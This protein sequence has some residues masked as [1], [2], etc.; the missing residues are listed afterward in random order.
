MKK[1][2]YIVI[3]NFI[4]LNAQTIENI[5]SEID[6]IKKQLNITEINAEND[7]QAKENPRLEN[8]DGEDIKQNKDMDKKLSKDDNNEF[9]N[10]D[11]IYEIIDSL[12]V[13]TLEYFGYKIFKGDPNVFQASTF[14]AVDP[15]Y[16]IGPG[17][18]IIVM[19][20]GESQFRQEFIIDREGYVFLPEVGQVFVN[21][22][23]LKALEKKIF[24]ILSKVYSTL[25]PAIGKPTTFMDISL[26]NL[27]PLRI[28]VLGDVSQPGSYSVSPSTSLSSSLY[29]FNGPT[30]KG[31]LRDIQL[32][33]KGKYIGSI[34]FY[35][36]LLSG[37]SPNDLRMQLDDIVFIPPRGK[38]VTILGEINREGIYELKDKEGLLD[39]INISGN[40]TASAYIKRAQISR[41]IP[42]EER[43]VA[44]MDRIL[45]DID[46]GQTIKSN[47][48]VD[49]YDGDTLKIFEIG[50]NIK[51]YV[52]ISG[53]TVQRPGKYQ[54]IENMKVSDLIEAADGLSKDVF[55][56]L[57]H[58]YRLNADLSQEVIAIDINNVMNGKENDDIKLKFMDQLI[59]YD[60]NRIQNKF[61]TVTITG[62]VKTPGIY[63]LNDNKKLNDII[64]EAGGFTSKVENVKIIVS[65]KEPDT[66]VPNIFYF[67]NNKNFLSSKELENNIEMNNFLLQAN[68]IVS[69]YADPR[70]TI[71]STINISG[72][73]MFPGNYPIR[74]KNDK[75]TD[76]IEISGGLNDDAYLRASTLIRN[77]NKINISFDKI[78]KNQ[79]NDQNFNV[80]PGDSIFISQK[81]NLV[82]VLGEVNNPG[83][84]KYYPSYNLNDYIRI[85]G[86]LTV[87]AE[88]KEIWVNY[89]DG[90]SKQ[91]N[92]F[93]P[94][95]KVYDGSAINVGIKNDTEPVNKTEL[96][97]EM[98]SIFADFLNIYISMTLLIRTAEG[99]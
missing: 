79:R 7:D 31:S 12:V 95:P 71:V 51:N 39:L 94:S 54:L 90:V 58:I 35:D 2:V 38:T 63:N 84:F 88:R 86:G 11:D 16:N 28:I 92:R 98:A 72:A 26:G 52:E 9:D 91:Y 56:N 42:P 68:D 19:L 97:K 77:G 50:S 27:R 78:I 40:L 81:F 61:K 93:F 70:G 85:S 87:D 6:L 80:L 74:T 59:V 17:D 46:L 29:Y 15:N 64:I 34:D 37:S 21:G 41:I 14:G 8:L 66:I 96:A 43:Y 55:L 62:P 82:T 67:P 22:L 33:R 4:F 45:L 49:L 1:F 24:Q 3:F 20:W 65:R 75:V 36:Y 25:N 60:K 30:L 13:D 69:L 44:N 32:L 89:P 23:N 83:L 76:I 47:L 73:V 10:D 48:N 57:A 18:E 5:Q 53:A 99:L